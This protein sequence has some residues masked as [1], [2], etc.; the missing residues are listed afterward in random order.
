LQIRNGDITGPNHQSVSIM[1]SN[2]IRIHVARQPP[3]NPG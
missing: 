2:E 1:P 3:H